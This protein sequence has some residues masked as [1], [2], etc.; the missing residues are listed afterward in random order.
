MPS[1]VAGGAGSTRALRAR[2]MPE[3]GSARPPCLAWQRRHREGWRICGGRV[4]SHSAVV[5]CSSR[6]RERSSFAGR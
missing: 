4:L 5:G 2:Q 1:T 3:C 6:P